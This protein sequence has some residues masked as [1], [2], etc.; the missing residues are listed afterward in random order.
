MCF[1]P[2]HQSHSTQAR[3]PRRA[4]GAGPI[5]SIT[6][7]AMSTTAHPEPEPAAARAL[8]EIIPLSALI[9]E[10]TAQLSAAEQVGQV[11][12]V[13]HTD[14]TG[15]TT[16]PP[17]THNADLPLRLSTLLDALSATGP[18]R[19]PL[20]PGAAEAAQSM[21]GHP[22]TKHWSL[23]QLTA[24]AIT[25]AAS[26]ALYDEAEQHGGHQQDTDPDTTPDEADLIPHRAVIRRSGQTDQSHPETH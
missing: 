23:A 20:A 19:R 24:R 9:D 2:A 10:V 8:P 3:H 6:L 15:N 25:L 7:G 11:E 26:E 1:S 21:L 12:Q 16:S 5:G 14:N 4:C 13:G 22:T 17:A 18:G